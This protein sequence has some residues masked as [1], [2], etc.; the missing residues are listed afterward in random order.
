MQAG[1]LWLGA[2]QPP[3]NDANHNLP[4]T[5]VRLHHAAPL[6]RV[7]RKIHRMEARALAD[8]AIV[9]LQDQAYGRFQPAADHL[10]DEHEGCNLDV[11]SKKQ[12]MESADRVDVCQ[13]LM[14]YIR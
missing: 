10:H 4:T 7:Q 3:Q 12:K 8:E 13:G 9:E 2:Q 6:H 14:G 5:E 11:G 1:E